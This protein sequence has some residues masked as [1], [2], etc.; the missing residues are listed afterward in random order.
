[1]SSSE[2]PRT[3]PAFQAEYTGTYAE[4]VNTV[5]QDFWKTVRNVAGKCTFLEEA[6]A[7]YYCAMDPATPY[8]AKAGLFS[9]LAYFVLPI[10]FVVDALPVLGLADDAAV[11]SA[12]VYLFGRHIQQPHRDQAKVV[13][14]EQLKKLDEPREAAIEPFEYNIAEA[15][16]WDDIVAVNE[17]AGAGNSS[18]SKEASVRVESQQI[19]Q[20]DNDEWEDVLI[21]PNPNTG[22]NSALEQA[23]TVTPNTQVSVEGDDIAEAVESLHVSKDCGTEPG[24]DTEAKSNPNT[25]TKFD[26]TSAPENNEAGP[27][28]AVLDKASSSVKAMS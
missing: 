1:M 9:A 3:A 12:A 14:A 21:V 20:A 27:S 4:N 19:A 8:Y 17:F 11:I 16:D 25:A 28:S 2:A 10:D 7:L 23:A 26:A 6:I 24:V 13:F 18:I 15:E 22:A 5:K